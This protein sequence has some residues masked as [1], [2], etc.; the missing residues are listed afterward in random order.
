MELFGEIPEA[1]ISQ[2]S[3]LAMFSND[4]HRSSSE[5]SNE[6]NSVSGNFVEKNCTDVLTSSEKKNNSDVITSFDRGL[7]RSSNLINHILWDQSRQIDFC[8]GS[9]VCDANG[10]DNMNYHIG[11]VNPS[12]GAKKS[13]LDKLPYFMSGRQPDLASRSHLQR[14]DLSHLRMEKFLKDQ[15][16]SVHSDIWR[17][18]CLEQ[19]FGN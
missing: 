17:Q 16:M 4:P 6:T 14:N 19:K 7:L 3:C 8:N 9:D 15:Q 18:Q 2:S 5:V 12:D 11:Y 13:Q 10:H 1:E